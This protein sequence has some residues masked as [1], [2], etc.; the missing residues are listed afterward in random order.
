MA[1]G[2]DI[3]G[4]SLKKKRLI[5]ALS[6]SSGALYGRR[7]LEVLSQT[8]YEVHWTVSEAASKVIHHEMGITLDLSDG[9]DAL[10]KLIGRAAPRFHYHSC[11]DVSAP[12]ASGSFQ[13]A[14]MAILPCSMGT[15]GRIASGVSVNLIDRAAD[16][17]LKERRKLVVVPRE[18]PL[19]EIHLDNMLR[20][21]RAG[22]T[23]LPASPGFYAGV[24]SVDQLVDFI[25]GR[26]LDHL[27]LDHDLVPWYGEAEVRNFAV[28][29]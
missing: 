23:I 18:T 1:P 14:G 17:C 10:H 6:G 28:E 8:T 5:V 16:V 25:V 3:R 20:I 15:I 13:T 2:C 4:S 21:T 12:I 11:R 26:V 27:G 22:G 9:V 7:L 29:E 24:S 19:S